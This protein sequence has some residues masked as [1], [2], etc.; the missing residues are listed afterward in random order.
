[1]GGN[2]NSFY[3]AL[4]GNFSMKAY[5]NN[6]IAAF[7]VQLAH[8]IDLDI[9]RWTVA[10]CEFSCPPPNVGSLKSHE[11]VGDTNAMIYFNFKT[12]QI[13]SHLKVRCLR[14]FIH[15]TVFCNHI[16]ENMLHT[17]QKP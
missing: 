7:T 11:V 17:C 13:V 4:F 2:P 16:F 14:I 12:P 1:M 3:V 9:D 10:L 5:P 8:E 15:P 6:T